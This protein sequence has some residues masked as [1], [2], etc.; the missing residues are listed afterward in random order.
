MLVADNVK[1]MV[2]ALTMDGHMDAAEAEHLAE[3]VLFNAL[4]LHE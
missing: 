3:M 4:S 2:G 1:A